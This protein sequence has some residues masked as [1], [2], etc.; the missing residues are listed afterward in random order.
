MLVIKNLGRLNIFYQV[1]FNCIDFGLSRFSGLSR[2]HH[3]LCMSNF[4][5]VFIGFLVWK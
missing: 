2:N 5:C 1:D 4:V 3:Y